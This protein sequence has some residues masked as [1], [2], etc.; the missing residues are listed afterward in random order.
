MPGTFWRQPPWNPPR[1]RFSA[2]GTL[3]LF[4]TLSI[5]P[6]AESVVNLRLTVNRQG[7]SQNGR[8]FRDH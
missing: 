8:H 7:G 2:E 4:G 6:L 1:N 3:Q 5:T